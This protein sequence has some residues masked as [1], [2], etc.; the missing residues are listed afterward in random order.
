M[1][2]VCVSRGCT[3]TSGWFQHWHFWQLGLPALD[4][5]VLDFRR[6]CWSWCLCPD[7]GAE[8][9]G[10]ELWK[11]RRRPW[12]AL[13]LAEGQLRPSSVQSHAQPPSPLGPRYF[14]GE[15]R[16]QAVGQGGRSWWEVTLD[17]GDA[18]GVTLER[19]DAAGPGALYP[20]A[21]F[22]SYRLSRV[23]LLGTGCF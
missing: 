17:G 18:A 21:A 14:P 4:P 11:P 5:G 16:R 20:E 9:L 12:L 8:G 19:G 2:C 23:E 6:T 15:P 1:A 7:G 3:H 22:G 10:G 13:V